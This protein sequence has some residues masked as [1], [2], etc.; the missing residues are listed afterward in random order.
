MPWIECL[1]F[2]AAITVLASFCMTTISA[3]RIFAIAS[4]VLFISYGLLGHIY[5][6][7]FLHVALLPVNLVK[8]HRLSHRSQFARRHDALRS[9]DFLDGSG[10]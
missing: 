6:V 10:G 5:P 2:C 8:L 9:I 7:F 4:N 3:L 1:G